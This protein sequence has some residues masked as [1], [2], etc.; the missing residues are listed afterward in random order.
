M[1]VVV[2]EG[3]GDMMVLLGVLVREVR[4]RVDRWRDGGWRC[5]EGRSRGVCSSSARAIFARLRGGSLV[6]GRG[7]KIFEDFGM[8]LR[9]DRV[10]N[11]L[12]WYESVAEGKSS[13]DLC[14]HTVIVLFHF[15]F[16]RQA[17][18]CD[19]FS[20]L[21]VP[22]EQLVS[23]EQV[24]VQIDSRIGHKVSVLLPTILQVALELADCAVYHVTLNVAL[25]FLLKV[26]KWLRILLNHLLDRVNE[27]IRL[28]VQLEA[29]R[30]EEES[31][32]SIDI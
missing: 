17:N 24:N 12:Q 9:L 6:V 7:W 29:S 18:G 3:G 1:Y 19:L 23:H 8:F 28:A 25:D 32:H 11:V 30:V 31:F 13:W 26:C 20:Q 21:V 16:C 15:S 2:V 27:N 22:V 10:V 14:M 4:V 5:C